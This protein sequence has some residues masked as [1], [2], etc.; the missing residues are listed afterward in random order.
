VA[1]ESDLVRIDFSITSVPLSGMEDLID[2]KT[3]VGHAALD[4][5]LPAEVLLLVGFVLGSRQLRGDHFRV[6]QSG[7]DIPMAA[8]VS[9]EESGGASVSPAV[10]RKNDERVSSSAGRC[11]AHSALPLLCVS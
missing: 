9:A 5:C 11:I 6:V 7:D 10:V 8:Q 3:R 1:D 2:E 4:Y